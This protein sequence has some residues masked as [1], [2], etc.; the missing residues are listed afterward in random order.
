MKTKKI[1]ALVAAAAVTV[2][3]FAA[4]VPVL[5]S[6]EV[7]TEVYTQNFDDPVAAIADFDTTYSF[8]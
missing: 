3:L 4:T 8:G 1:A 2:G 7:E 6:A 5:A